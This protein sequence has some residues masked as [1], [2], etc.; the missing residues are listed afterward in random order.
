[1]KQTSDL[2]NAVKVTETSPFIDITMNAKFK[3]VIEDLPKWIKSYFT[4]LT[5]VDDLVDKLEKIPGDATDV[6]KN[7]PDDFENLEFM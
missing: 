1:M 7:A 3:E 2:K 4:A 5:K 6:A